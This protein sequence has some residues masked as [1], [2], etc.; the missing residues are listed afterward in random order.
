VN[1]VKPECLGDGVCTNPRCE[2][3]GIKDTPV[4]TDEAV[5][6]AAQALRDR[7]TIF[8]SVGALAYQAASTALEAA[9]PLMGATP[10]LCHNGHPFVPGEDV[11]MVAEGRQPDPAWCNLCGEAR[12]D[13]TPAVHRR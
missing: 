9:A 4:V 6:A 10:D 11:D 2:R 3:H 1:G 5:E 8:S 12:R 7:W 13:A